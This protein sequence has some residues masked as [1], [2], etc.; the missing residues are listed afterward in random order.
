[1]RKKIGR[2]PKLEEHDIQELVNKFEKYVEETEIP[3]VVEFAYLNNL[4]RTFLYD[5]AEFSTVLK[6]CIQKKESQLE[7]GS[8][9]GVLNSTQAIFSLK[10]LGWKDKQEIDM[11]SDISL[12]KVPTENLLEIEK[13]LDGKDS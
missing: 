10:Q 2:P 12:H 13:L 5:R 7:K 4:D 11:K 8:L 6:K 1:M 9:M 3:I